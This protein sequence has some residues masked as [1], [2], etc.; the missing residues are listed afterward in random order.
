MR[1]Y[2]D[3]TIP[4]MLF[5]KS[6]F[7]HYGGSKMKDAKIQAKVERIMD[8]CNDIYDALNERINRASYAAAYKVPATTTTTADVPK[9][10]A[11]KAKIAKVTT[12]IVAEKV[13]KVAAPSRRYA[14][15]ALKRGRVPNWVLELARCT[16]KKELI[17]RY[18]DGYKFI[19]GTKPTAII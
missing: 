16:D 6:P 17:A 7:K 19:E 18:G 5:T 4:G 1:G 15:D 8:I 10:K 13:A 11:R 3:T 9:V 14:P 2:C 12:K